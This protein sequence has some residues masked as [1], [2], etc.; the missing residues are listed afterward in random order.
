MFNRVALAV[1][2][3]MTLLVGIAAPAAHAEVKQRT[4]VTTD[5]ELDDIN[6]LLRMFL[7]A[8][9]ISIEGLVYASGTHHYA[10][11]PAKGIPAYRW[12]L[13]QSHIEDAID[14]YD[15]VDE[16]LR[17]HDPEYPTAAQ[18]RST[19]R[20]GNIKVVNDMS[21]STPGSQLIADVLL[22]DNP[23]PVFLQAWGGLSTI[24]RGLLDIE[25][26]YK[27][28]PEWDAIYAKVSKKA[29]ITSFGTQDTA[30]TAYILPNWPQIENRRVNTNIWGYG[31]RGSVL[32]EDRFL[33]DPEWT[34][35]NVSQVGP[36]GALYRVW[37]DGRFM[38]EFAGPQWEGNP[39]Q[40]RCMV[41]CPPPGTLYHDDEDYFGFDSTLPE[42]STANLRAR[43]YNVWTAP[44]APGAF[45]SEGDSS[46][47]ALLFRNG[48][49]NYENPRWGGWGG[50]QVQ[51]AT[52][53]YLFSPPSNATGDINPATGTRT[54]GY[55][56]SRWWR[57]I[58]MDFAERLRWSVTPTYAAANHEPVVSVTSGLNLRAAAGEQV[59]LNGAATD[60]DGN[61]LTYRWYQ[62]REAGTYPGAVTLANADTAA[63]GFQVPA[64]AQPGQTI[65]AILEVTDNG[66]RP[67]TRY[68]R[69]VVTVVA[70]TDVPGQVGGTVP[71]TLSLTL[72]NPATFGAFTPGVATDYFASTTA[73][74]ISSAG[75][76]TLSV[77]DPS[78]T[79]TGKL[80]NGAF[81]LPQTLQARARNA[82]TT[83][84]PYNNVGS[85]ASPLNLLT[86]DNPISN[87]AVTLEFKQSIG[88]NDALRTGTYSKTLTFTL[89]T[90]A[91]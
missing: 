79:N 76:A 43:G 64:D 14:A 50:R 6:S 4:I 52:N 10:G 5:P 86:W 47:F 3:A 37:G 44:Q 16:N 38:A 27:N 65:H 13:G 87:D 42:N 18:L 23:G 73:N 69:V 45:I 60:P 41:N 55:H 51:N 53:P 40:D 25:Q 82:T 46:N 78:A 32:P 35:A 83:S 2:A 61:E 90:T 15:Q 80:V 77:A 12:K 8:D 22:D 29:I 30:Y 24:A 63:S 33:L 34:R 17:A 39:R 71:A 89:S 84:P 1:L 7:Y 56:A 31:A 88:A 11:D 21:E 67:L 28:T 26:R 62:Y 74:V 72:G 91:P 81:V 85:S 19:Y 70:K 58:Q 49:R 66:A 68:Q 20:V 9:D 57:A 48:L 36:M 54:N 59:P 75:N